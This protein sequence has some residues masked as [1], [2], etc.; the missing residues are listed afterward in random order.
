MTRPDPELLA[1]RLSDFVRTESIHPDPDW[2]PWQS[3][4]YAV[5]D[6][7][8]SSQARYDSVVLPLLYDRFPV[9]SGLADT[10]EL[11]FSAFLVSVGDPTPER[12][13]AY[14]VRIM[15]TRHKI[16]GRLKVE[17]ALDVCQFFAAR[18]YETRAHLLAL[19]E[20]RLADLVLDE[21]VTSVRGIGPVLGRYLLLLLGL[22]QFVKPDTLL[23]RLL[24]RVGGWTP[25]LGNERDMQLIQGAVAAVAAELQVAPARLD[26]ALW[27]YE[28]LGLSTSPRP[29]AAP[30]A[31]HPHSPRSLAHPSALERRRSQLDEPRHAPLTSYVQQLRLQVRE[32]GLE[33][34]DLDPLGGGRHTRILYLLEA[35]GPKAVPLRGGSGFVSMDNDDPTAQTVF[36][37]TQQAGVNRDW[38]SL[39]NIVPWYAGDTS[40]IRAVRPAEIQA[41]RDHL[42]QLLIRLP[43]LRVVVTLGAPAALGWSALA[44][45][46]AHVVTLSTWHA[47][48]QAL[49]AH[50]ERRTHLLSTL[51]L[52]QQVAQ[53]SVDAAGPKWATI[54]GFQGSTGV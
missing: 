37:L 13:E 15:G 39:W 30:P 10:P 1:Q 38:V 45:D 42:R 33:V 47:G 31:H 20:Q 25:M 34:P 35:P 28:S 53:H 54:A 7:V 5:L 4:V 18:G 6:C 27:L 8:Y 16:S 49:N 9:T 52:A 19:G 51:H 12:L 26:H 36:Q 29:R 48:G 32:Q 21:L 2:Q 17:V 24:G 3:G 46:F 11:T 43:E 22:E 14:A 41:G 23:S 50:P 40:R 44:A